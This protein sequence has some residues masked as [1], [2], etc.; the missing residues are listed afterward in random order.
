MDPTPV[1][2]DLTGLVVPNHYMCKKNLLQLEILGKETLIEIIIFI[3]M[4]M[5][6]HSVAVALLL[7][8]LLD[9]IHLVRMFG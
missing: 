8:S 5:L 9:I 4:Q 7:H 3:I 2:S 6:N 1:L